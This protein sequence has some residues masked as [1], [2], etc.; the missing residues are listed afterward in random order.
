VVA[1]DWLVD[2]AVQAAVPAGDLVAGG[3]AEGKA[4]AAPARRDGDKERRG[5]PALRA[6]LAGLVKRGARFVLNSKKRRASPF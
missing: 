5:L 2:M 6:P 1:A 4:S 3:G